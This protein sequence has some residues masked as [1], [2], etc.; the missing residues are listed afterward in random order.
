MSHITYWSDKTFFVSL[1]TLP[2]PF[3]NIIYSCRIKLMKA[4]SLKTG[5]LA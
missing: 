1:K 4:K 2:P 5:I 3:F